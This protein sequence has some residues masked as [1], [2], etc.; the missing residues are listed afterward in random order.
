MLVAQIQFEILAA[1]NNKKGGHF[2]W[3]PFR[4]WR[5]FIPRTGSGHPARAR[6]GARQRTV[7]VAPMLE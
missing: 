1:Q 2:W 4:N 7:E 3:P 6:L 5:S